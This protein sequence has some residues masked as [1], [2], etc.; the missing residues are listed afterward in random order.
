MSDAA[1]SEMPAQDL[2]CHHGLSRF[3]LSFRNGHAYCFPACIVHGEDD[4]VEHLFQ[5]AVIRFDPWDELQPVFLCGLFKAFDLGRY[6]VLRER[7]GFCAELLFSAAYFV[8][9]IIAV[10]LVLAVHVKITCFSHT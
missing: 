1:R 6:A 10:E 3:V 9:G 5:Y 7:D 8:G 2:F 4:Q